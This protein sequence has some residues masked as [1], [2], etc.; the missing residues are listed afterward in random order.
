M[1]AVGRDLQVSLRDLSFGYG[2]GDGS[3]ELSAGTRQIGCGSVVAVYGPNGSGKTTLLRLLANVLRPRSGE[4]HWQ[5]N[6][7]LLE[8]PKLGT[9]LV[10]TN[11]AGPFP[12]WTVRENL[13]LGDREPGMSREREQHLAQTWGLDGLLQRRAHELSAGQLQRVVLARALGVDARAYLFDEITSAQSESWCEAIGLALRALAAEGRVVLAVSHDPVW[14]GAF[15]DRVLELGT[16]NGDNALSS[17]GLATR[18]SVVHDGPAA[19][20]R[21]EDHRFRAARA[22]RAGRS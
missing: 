8:R 19:T 22:A 1:T 13:Q 7:Q 20:W 16:E 12:H 18:F 17:N 4:V 10:V 5:V 3:F 15:A 11:S 14:V 6:G 21:L 9:D 2:Q